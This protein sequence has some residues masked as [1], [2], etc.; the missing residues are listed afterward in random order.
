MIILILFFLTTFL[1]TFAFG[2][3]FLRSFHVLGVKIQI[4]KYIVADKIFLG[5]FALVFLASVLNFWLP[6]NIYIT[7]PIVLISLVHIFQI[8]KKEL[9][10]FQK[11][12]KYIYCGALALIIISFLSLITHDTGDSMYYHMQ[13]IE[14]IYEYPIIKGIA[15][16]EDRFGFNSS[17]FIFYPLVSFKF[18]LHLHLFELNYFLYG[19]IFWY[20]LCQ[21]TDDFSILNLCYLLILSASFCID[22]EGI[23]STTNDST[24]ALCGLFLAIRFLSEKMNI[25]M[26]YIFIPCLMIT[27]K[28]SSIF[29]MFFSLFTILLLFKEK[30]AK[31]AWLSIGICTG[32]MLCWI[33]RNIIISG[34]IIYPFYYLDPFDFSWKVPKI[35]AMI[36]EAYIKDYANFLGQKFVSQLFT[37]SLKDNRF[38]LLQLG[39]IL[40]LFVPITLIYLF[41]QKKIAKIIILTIL[42]IG[43]IFTFSMTPDF[44]FYSS[45]FYSIL[46]ILIYYFMN[47]KFTKA[48]LTIKSLI[49]LLSFSI[50]FYTFYSRNHYNLDSIF[51]NT[52]NVLRLFYR[53]VS[54]ITLIRFRNQNEL[55]SV[56]VNNFDMIINLDDLGLKYHTYE[57]FPSSSSTGYPN[58]ST[59]SGFKIQALE[60][61]EMNGTSIES[62][63]RTT[64]KWKKIFRDNEEQIFEEYKIDINKRLYK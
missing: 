40:L 17:I 64:D 50:L 55:E 34:Y 60:T 32:F 5:L 39:H 4:E 35:V 6:I 10:F 53:P 27:T 13:F 8:V 26:L 43:L 51:T 20:I 16:L 54:D 7:I 57:L 61:I 63:F 47:G 48:H 52:R 58:T 3:L 46:V 2:D 33:I 36:Q 37:F 15:N 49:L 19:V 23:S 45:Y 31:I 18:F 12:K 38:F 28:L 44:R 62:G 1:I 29:F 11:N 30:K 41:K 21:I 59:A 25:Y 56:R 14:S 22:F 24:V 42:I 9:N